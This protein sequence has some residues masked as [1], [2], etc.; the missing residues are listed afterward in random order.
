MNV[1][2]IIYPIFFIQLFTFVLFFFFFQAEDGIRDLTVTGVQTCALPICSAPSSSKRPLA[3]RQVVHV[4]LFRNLIFTLGMPSPVVAAE[5]AIRKEAASQQE[6]RSI[7]RD[8]GID[9]A[10]PAL[11]SSGQGLGFFE[12]LK[13]QPRRRIQASHAVMALTNQLVHLLQDIQAAAERAQ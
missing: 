1:C 12:S 6:H 5:R 7:S 4:G 2:Y 3:L 9:V 10:R 11:D 13:T 8:F